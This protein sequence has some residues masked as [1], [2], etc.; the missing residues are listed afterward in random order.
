MP[1]T[2]AHLDDVDAQE[3]AAA[4]LLAELLGGYR[5]TFQRLID[6]DEL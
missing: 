5:A 2:P 1:A 6:T 3:A 4:V